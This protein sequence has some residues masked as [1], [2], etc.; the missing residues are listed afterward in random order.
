MLETQPRGLPSFQI[1]MDLVPLQIIEVNCHYY[2]RADPKSSPKLSAR[3]S[4]APIPGKRQFSFR[5]Q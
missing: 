4:L 5:F 1:P 3:I 2:R